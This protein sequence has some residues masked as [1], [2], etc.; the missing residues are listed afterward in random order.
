[1]LTEL[2]IKNLAVVD[3]LTIS[4]SQGMSA[5]TGETGAGKSILLQ[6]LNLVL[7]ARGDSNLVRHQQQQADISAVFNIENNMRA[8]VFLQEQALA[9]T[10]ECILRRVVTQTGKSK[11]FINGV[12][13]PLSLLRS[14]GEYLI[15]IH[16]QNEHQLLLKP[17]YQLDLLDNYAQLTTLKSTLNLLVSEH[18][19]L[20]AELENLKNNQSIAL[21]EKTLYIDQLEVLTHAELTQNE[22][23]TIELDFKKSA[24]AQALIEKTL[25]VLNALDG[26]SGINA[27][28]QSLLG[29]FLRLSGLDESLNSS[30]ELLN[31]AQLQAQESIYELTHYLSKLSV[32]EAKTNALEARLSE[33]HDLSRKHHCLISELLTV[34]TKLAQQLESLHSEEDLFLMLEKKILVLEERYCVQAEMLSQ[35]RQENA[36]ILSQRVTEAMQVLG[37]PGAE[38]LIDLPKKTAGVSQNGVESVEFLIKTNAG[39]A[40]KTLRKIASGGELSRISLALS[41]ISS[42]NQYTSSLVFDE[43]DVGIS[44]AVAE[45]VGQHLRELSK[46]YQLICITH[47]AQVAS[48]AHQH[49]QV[50]KTQ[51]EEAT[52]AKI[53]TLSGGQRIDEIARILGGVVIT[54]KTRKAAEEMVKL[55]SVDN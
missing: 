16:G 33:L 12:S 24:N 19:A 50:S 5:I 26:D 46:H 4:F 34:Q 38:F 11:A 47:L 37:M 35:Q 45:V 3:S 29:D 51:N 10:E 41:V 20:R 53:R 42:D 15:D 7:G 22:L 44:G 17:I 1:M 13:V 39:Q 43:V 54:D 36:K 28:L 14:L 9:E 55:N 52:Y 21:Q 30:Y 2:S 27:Q 6:A 18:K 32:D 8:Q 31:S 25:H 48:F 49:L 40:P 23:N